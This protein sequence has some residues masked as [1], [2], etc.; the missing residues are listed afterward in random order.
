MTHAEAAQWLV[1]ESNLMEPV[2]GGVILRV[3]PCDVFVVKE[4]DHIAALQAREQ[5]I[6]KLAQKHMTPGDYL[7][8]EQ[9]AKERHE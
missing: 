6:M 1:R 9:A 8:L 5:A 7:R 4:A 3:D 2:Q